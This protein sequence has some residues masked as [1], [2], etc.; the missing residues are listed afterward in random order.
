MLLI[1][2]TVLGFRTENHAEAAVLVPNA[3][4]VIDPVL[5]TDALPSDREVLACGPAGRL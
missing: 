5:V 2:L 1:G 4:V 3:E